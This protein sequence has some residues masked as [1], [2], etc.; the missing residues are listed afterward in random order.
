MIWTDKLERRFGH[1]AIPG[2]TRG[3][4]ALQAL[5]FFLVIMNPAFGAVLALDPVAVREG[6]V[7]RLVSYI[8]LPRTTSLLW[9][10]FALYILWL[11]GE[12]LEEAWGPFKLNLYILTGLVCMAGAALIF[13]APADGLIFW[14]SLFFAFATIF[15]N[16]TFLLFFILPVKVK[17]LALFSAGFLLLQV[18]GPSVQL[19]AT[20]AAIVLNYGLFFGQYWIQHFKNGAEIKTRRARFESSKMPEEATLHRCKVCDRTEA[21]D[22]RLDFR[23][24]ADGE[25]YCVEHLPK[26]PESS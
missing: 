9:I 15:P 14:T 26:R 4:V 17:W 6:Q 24:A 11:V 21:S 2:I 5:V 12:A 13:N 7:W 3:I 19:K 20:A 10:I 18:L 8:F 16:Y 1:L 23:V 22:P 25:E